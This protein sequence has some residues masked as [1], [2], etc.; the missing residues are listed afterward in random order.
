MDVP[1]PGPAAKLLLV[2]FQARLIDHYNDDVLARL[3][4][5]GVAVE[6]MV[7]GFQLGQLKE[8]KRVEGEKADK[9]DEA[10]YHSDEEALFLLA[11]VLKGRHR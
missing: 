10:D 6:T 2:G 7:Q 5:I 11:Q 9:D 4:G 3:G 1:R 8:A